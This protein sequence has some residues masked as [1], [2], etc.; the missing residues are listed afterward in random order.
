MHEKLGMGF[1][2]PGKT[3]VEDGPY[4][5]THLRFMPFYAQCHAS[6]RQPKAQAPDFKESYA[7]GETGL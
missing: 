2:P 7:H 1:L 6:I 4:R 5:E 3:E